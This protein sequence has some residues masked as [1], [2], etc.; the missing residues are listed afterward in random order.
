MKVSYSFKSFFFNLLYASWISYLQ[1]FWDPS[2]YM[3]LFGM[4]MYQ[5][6]FQVNSR[7]RYLNHLLYNWKKIIRQSIAY[8][9]SVWI[10]NLHRGRVSLRHGVHFIDIDSNLRRTVVS[11]PAFFFQLMHRLNHFKAQDCFVLI[12]TLKPHKFTDETK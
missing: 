3:M 10:K 1:S 11:Y 7:V 2:V 12:K 4:K 9:L 8:W 6:Y 5:F